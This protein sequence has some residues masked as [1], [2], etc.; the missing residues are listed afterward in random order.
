MAEALALLSGPELAAEAGDGTFVRGAVFFRTPAKQGH[1]PP[2][3]QE[4]QWWQQQQQG[5]PVPPSQSQPSP[6]QPSPSQPSPVRRGSGSIGGV[7]G[8]DGEDDGKAQ[9]RLSNSMV[10][11]SAAAA[12]S[13][14]GRSSRSGSSATASNTADGGRGSVAG[15]KGDVRDSAVENNELYEI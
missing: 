15:R 4:Q 1:S 10:Y 6:S 14:T 13:M 8:T 9:R 3:P 5:A 12:K 11:R 7:G 2:G